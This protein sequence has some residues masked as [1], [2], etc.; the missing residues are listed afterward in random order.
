VAAKRAIVV[1]LSQ[2]TFPTSWGIRMLVLGAK[3]VTNK[4]GK[5]VLSSAVRAEDSGD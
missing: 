1:D 5:I 3:A 4:G 2:V